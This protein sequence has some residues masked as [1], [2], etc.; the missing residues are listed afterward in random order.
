MK[1]QNQKADESTTAKAPE[2]TLKGLTQ[3][4]KKATEMFHTANES[5]AKAVEANQQLKNSI[6]ML[7]KLRRKIFVENILIF[8]SAI[9]V[10]YGCGYGLY[11][12]TYGGFY[13]ALIFVVKIALIMLFLVSIG[14]CAKKIILLFKTQK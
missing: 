3:R 12:L 9:A 1:K 13:L 10:I 6:S 8:L 4:I 2:V 14:Y 7:K 5:T 11:L